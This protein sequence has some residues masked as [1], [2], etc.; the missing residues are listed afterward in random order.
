VHKFNQGVE[1]MNFNKVCILTCALSSFTVSQAATVNV[2]TIG[3]NL[4][5]YSDT[6]DVVVADAFGKVSDVVSVWKWNAATSTWAFY[7]PALPG[8]GQAY[9]LSK[10][11]DFL[12]TIKSG[13]GFWVNA[14]A[15]FVATLPAPTSQVVNPEALAGI[16]QGLSTLQNLFATSLPP[17]TDPG[18]VAMID[19][20][21]LFEGANKAQF[22]QGMSL[23]YGPS[24]GAKFGNPKLVNPLDS[25]A[26]PNDATHQWF[27]FDM[28]PGKGLDGAWLAVKSA[29]GSWL[30][31]G[32]QRQFGFYVAAEAAKHIA[33]GG[34][35]TYTNSIYS[36]LNN[37][38]A[39]V[40]NLVLTGAGVV[41]ATGISIYT[42][43]NGKISQNTCG[44]FGNTT[45][46]IDP[47]AASAGSPH[48][49]KVYTTAGGSTVPAFS[50]TNLLKRGPLADP[51]T[52]TYPNI[53]GVTS[54][55][56]AGSAVAVN[57]TLPVGTYASWISI[58]AWNAN[59]Q[60]FNAGINLSPN[61]TSA[62]LVVPNYSGTPTG[63]NVWLQT[64]DSA[65]N[66]LALDYQ[67]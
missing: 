33:V 6:S 19:D 38:P 45:N 55:W 53:T 63:K 25:G 49:L 64:N 59:A 54:A 16:T 24:V 51:S 12:T 39:T 42:S 17:A 56:T 23:G 30:L 40:T 27:T 37:V 41:P 18:L 66:Y 32:D 13:D 7:S 46:C 20:S 15:T 60:L 58:G 61:Q 35:V 22:L 28:T 48:T 62:Q 65:G 14:K 57:W 29:S 5:G 34:A 4:L 50:Y 2:A 9:A 3:W 26:V 67:Q 44:L 47:A 31:A 1:K 36:N 8:G 10:G 52:G 21:M 43:A 11:Y